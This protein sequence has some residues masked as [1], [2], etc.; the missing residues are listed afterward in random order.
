MSSRSKTKK[1]K[2]ETGSATSVVPRNEWGSF[3][4]TFARLHRGWLTRLETNDRVTHETVVS[5]EMPLQSIELD[6]EDEKNPRINVSIKLDNKDL[7]HI[8]F[9]PSRLILRSSNR[10]GVESLQ[11]DTLNTETT[12]YFRPQEDSLPA[13]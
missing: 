11:V 7:K 12:V 5:Q 1:T 13:M 3:L 4:A 8:L 2:S 9:L 6:L 10:G